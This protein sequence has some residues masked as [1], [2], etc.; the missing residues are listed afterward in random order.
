MDSFVTFW[1]KTTTFTFFFS[2][3]ILQVMEQIPRFT[4][5]TLPF[6]ETFITF[7]SLDFHVA[8]LCR[9]PRS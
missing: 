1:G 9:T 6:E 3:P 7:M 2:A 5:T 8:V 4:A